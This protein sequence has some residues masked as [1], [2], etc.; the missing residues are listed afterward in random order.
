MR[1]S[2]VLRAENRGDSNQKKKIVKSFSH[3]AN[4]ENDGNNF[5]RVFSKFPST[6]N[7][8]R[9]FF[10][11]S[12]RVF[13]EQAPEYETWWCVLSLGLNC[14]LAQNGSEYQTN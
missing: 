14:W 11:Y 10:V 13:I 3:R 4:R 8:F 7:N 6:K 9:H 1:D 12:I 5:L 2:L